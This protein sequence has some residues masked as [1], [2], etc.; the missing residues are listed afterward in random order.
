MPRKMMN[1]RRS[2]RPAKRANNNSPTARNQT[3]YHRQYVG[4]DIEIDV[5]PE[6]G[7]VIAV[8]PEQ[9]NYGSPSPVP[10]YTTAFS[11]FFGDRFSPVWRGWRMLG[12]SGTVLCNAKTQSPG[13]SNVIGVAP[14]NL[15]KN[16]YIAVT[17]NTLKPPL[18]MENLCELPN[19]KVLSGDTANAR[20][21]ANFSY[22]QGRTDINSMPFQEC[23]PSGGQSPGPGTDNNVPS[24]YFTGILVF[25]NGNY[26]ENTVKV[27]FHGRMLVEFK[28]QRILQ[29]IERPTLDM[30]YLHLTSP[31]ANNTPQPRVKRLN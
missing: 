6:K 20:N 28:D 11:S 2:R 1:K 27:N 17:I 25:N 23:V 7:A 13:A 30:E 14:F 29:P 8:A 15:S 22:Y 19:V 26:T 18:A 21:R 12:W 4:F 31:R 5:E 3:K 24:L 16:D 10:Q 9:Y